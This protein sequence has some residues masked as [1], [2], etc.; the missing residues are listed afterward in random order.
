[1]FT[2]I[3]KAALAATAALTL[4]GVVAPAEAARNDWSGLG[5][6]P[7]WLTEIYA[8]IDRDNQAVKQGGAGAIIVVHDRLADAEN[9]VKAAKAAKDAA[10][11]AADAANAAATAAAD[12]AVAAKGAS[13]K[14]AKGLASNAVDAANAAA[15]KAVDAAIAAAKY[16]IAIAKATGNTTAWSY[17]N[18]AVSKAVTAAIAAANYAVRIAKATGNAS[19]IKAANAAIAAAKAANDLIITIATAGKG[20]AEPV[21]ECTG[22]AG[23][24][25]KKTGIMYLAGTDKGYDSTSRQTLSVQVIEDVQQSAQ[26]LLTNPET[27]GDPGKLVCETIGRVGTKFVIVGTKILILYA[28]GPLVIPALPM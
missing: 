20:I 21:L 25:A 23:R 26:H 22:H 6:E 17:A 9:Q 15:S 7:A 16:A 4:F 1:M 12:D 19:A 13:T 11:K 14:A 24:A 2:T 5:G 3:R 10:S 27:S 28:I 8:A 18:A